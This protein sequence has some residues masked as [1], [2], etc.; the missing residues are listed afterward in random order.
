MNIIWFKGWESYSQANSGRTIFHRQGEY[1]MQ[2]LQGRKNFSRGIKR[3]TLTQEDTREDWEAITKKSGLLV[4]FLN[5]CNIREIFILKTIVY[6][7]FKCNWESYIFY[8]LNMA[9]FV[10][11]DVKSRKYFK[12]STPITNHIYRAS[13]Q[14]LCM[15][16]L[17]LFPCLWQLQCP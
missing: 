2:S 9:T 12:E 3:S 13:C 17:I 6:L 10:I 11:R 4:K 16:Y 15:N 5:I 8:L 14:V 1:H 7:K